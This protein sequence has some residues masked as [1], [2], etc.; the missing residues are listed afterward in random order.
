MSKKKMNSLSLMAKQRSLK[1]LL[2]LNIFT[3][4]ILLFQST[5][6]VSFDLYFSNK[7]TELKP[8]FQKIT[9]PAEE[10]GNLSNIIT[11]IFVL[12]IINLLITRSFITLITGI[13]STFLVIFSVFTLK[14]LTARSGPSNS[15][16]SFYDENLT[17]LQGVFP[18]GHQ[19]L[20]TLAALLSITSLSKVINVKLLLL[21]SFSIILY[22]GFSLWYLSHHWLS[23][24]LYGFA[25]SIFWV[26]VTS[27]L[28]PNLLKVEKTNYS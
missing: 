25:L 12:L 22:E 27:A 16:G 5:L 7:G 26:Q 17:T 1:L 18:S 3:G 15:E 11:Y 20:V 14:V 2:V 6:F 28:I 9:N 21:F 24:I 4:L 19:A 10:I 8:F 23:D 13:I